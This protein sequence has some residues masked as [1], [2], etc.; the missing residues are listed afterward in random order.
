MRIARIILAGIFISF[1]G[2]GLASG[3]EKQD[4]P[5]NK[6]N[7]PRPVEVKLNVKVLDAAGNLAYDLKAGDIKIF[8]DG[9]EQ[10]ITYFARKR[11]ELNLGLVM[12]N[13]G[14]VRTQFKKLTMAG[15]HFVD[16]LTGAGEAFL[17]RFVSSGK[18]EIIQD[19]TS[20]KAELNETLGDMYIEGGQSAVIDALYLAVEKLLE[21]EK[22]D[23][24]RKYAVVLM[25][26]AEDRDSYYELSD[27]L[28]LLK[29]SDIQ[30]FI[31]GFTGQVG[32]DYV[33]F[34]K[35]K[36]PKEKSED[37]AQTIALQSGGRVHILSKKYTENDLKTIAESISDELRYQYVIGYTSTNQNRDGLARK[38]RVEIADGEK[39]E[40]RQGSIRESFVVPKN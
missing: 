4:K 24:Y 21:R 12:D 14:S 40:K 29:D 25:S 16:S 26:D 34:F 20:S 6:K 17:V 37:L 15:R 23:K 2:L 22:T 27:V 39:G 11:P 7:P 5:K 3:Q 18:I 36:G 31:I 1:L 9:V 10:Q 13:S 38:L 35:S 8:E 19:W 28:S 33:P 32:R 30:V